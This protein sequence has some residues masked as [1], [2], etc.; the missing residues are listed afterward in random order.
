MEQDKLGQ[1]NLSYVIS[2]PVLEWQYLFNREEKS[3]GKII[4]RPDVAL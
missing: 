1:A 2:L 3:P 4:S